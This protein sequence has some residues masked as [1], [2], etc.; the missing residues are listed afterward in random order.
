MS[1]FD[2]LNAREQLEAVAA[3]LGYQ[4]ED[5]SF[6]LKSMEDAIKLFRGWT[7]DPNLPEFCDECESDADRKMILA[8]T[9]KILG[10]DPW[11]RAATVDA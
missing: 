3:W 10:Y 4:N 9:T 11:T 5:L 2:E 7:T 8:R 6:G 1:K